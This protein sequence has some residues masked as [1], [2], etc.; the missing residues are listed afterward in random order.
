MGHSWTDL[1]FGHL[2]SGIIN[3]SRIG[4]CVATYTA[5]VSTTDPAKRPASFRVVLMGLAIVAVAIV[6]YLFGVYS[7]PRGLWP[8][9]ALR[10]LGDTVREPGAR[11]D[12]GRLTAYPGKIPV[13][14]PPQDDR[15]AVILAMGQSNVAN[16]G[17]RRETTRHGSHVVGYFDGKCHIAASPLLGATSDGGEFLTMLADWLVDDGL[18]RTVV[19][20]SSGVGASPISRWAR[21]GDLNASLS[22][23]LR[24]LAANYRVTHV[25]WHQGETDLANATTADAYKAAFASLIG[26]LGE[27]GV[28]APVFTSVSTRCAATWTAGNP[29]ALAQRALADGRRVVLATDADALLAPD[30][31]TDGCHY[32][33]AGQRK[34]A[35]AYAAAIRSSR[36]NH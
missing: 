23:R 16:H 15:T 12:F 9:G 20:V 11:D 3:W 31:R 4:A 25:I 26:T 1:L 14:C 21:D 8:I 24:Q 28:E 29:I 30:D 5:G 32:S 34:I 33:E 7:Y 22:S 36:S 13:A 18:Y 6:S 17:A 27:A 2:R 10:G 35:A 19:I